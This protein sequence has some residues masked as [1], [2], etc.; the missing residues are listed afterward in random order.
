MVKLFITA[1]LSSLAII[2]CADGNGRRKT[3]INIMTPEQKLINFLKELKLDKIKV[4]MCQDPLQCI[5]KKGI[6]V[7]VQGL[8][9]V[10]CYVL[11]DKDLFFLVKGG[12]ILGMIYGVAAVFEISGFRFPHPFFFI[13]P[14]DIDEESVRSAIARISKKIFEPSVAIRGLHLH[15]LH[16]TEAFVSFHFPGNF[17]EA[18]KIIRWIVLNRGNFVQ[19]VPLG[20][21]NNESRYK[22]WKDLSSRIIDYA[23]SIGVKVGVNVQIFSQ[24]SLQ[25]AYLLRTDENFLKIFSLPFD[26]VNLSFGEFIGEEPN[27][28]VRVLNETYEKIKSI[29]SSIEVHTTVHVGN[30]ENLR[31]EYNGEKLLYYFLVKFADPQIVNLVHTVMYYNLFDSAGGA[32][33][34]KD[35]SEHRDFLFQM[36]K[37]GRKT[38]YKPETSY[39]VA[40]DNSVPLYLPIYV[41]SR[42]L[43]IF[44]IFRRSDRSAIKNF[45]AHIIF[46]SGW[47]WGYWLN[48][49]VS[50]RVSYYPA[51]E[52]FSD[53]LNE[54]FIQK[55]VAEL[56]SKLAEVQYHYL[57]REELASYLS[58]EDFYVDLACQTK[59]IISQPCRI[60]FEDAK[61][62]RT[63]VEKI[64]NKLGIFEEQ[65][66]GIYH[67]LSSVD[68]KGPWKRIIDEIK[69]GV[70]ITYLRAN[71][72]RTLYEGIL[73]SEYNNHL[74]QMQKI[75]DEARKVAE[76]RYVEFFYPSP[77]ILVENFDNPTIYKFGYLKQAHTL[78]LWERDLERFKEAFG[79]KASKPTCIN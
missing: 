71:F 33:N 77:N 50:L 63:D 21:I 29:N 68:D 12:G 5:E 75:L 10:E 3:F 31:V 47:E 24:S 53:L 62:S 52:T 37:E 34:H 44:E 26:V 36:M 49:Y 51:P 69:D 13:E 64:L 70:L 17:E 2:S 14:Q 1:F 79:Q 48:D 66:K 9:C 40:F 46:S 72:I 55:D 56:V 8:E 45:Y 23:H 39:W 6:N 22:E 59:V 11:E 60:S 57:I 20:D 15:T 18:K 38:G 54:F 16:P 78:C 41:I 43:D 32:Y 67:S 7:F 27:T 4:S 35:F 76:R 42:W 25:N 74:E 65:M 30:F 28:F 61:K 58:G 73:N 19:W